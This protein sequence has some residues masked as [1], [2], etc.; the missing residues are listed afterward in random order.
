MP[1]LEYSRLGAIA[2]DFGVEGTGEHVFTDYNWAE[3]KR[4]EMCIPAHTEDG[5][6]LCEQW[7]CPEVARGSGFVRDL[8]HQFP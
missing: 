6:T 2:D 5:K 7:I 3:G 4:R 1:T 8:C